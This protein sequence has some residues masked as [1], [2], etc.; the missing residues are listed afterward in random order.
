M[1]SL[2]TVI[3]AVLDDFFLIQKDID[4]VTGLYWNV[5]REAEY[6][7]IKKVIQLT[8]RNKKKA[9][10][11]LG[12]SRNTLDSKLRALKINETDI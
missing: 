3:E 2:L 12:I 7:I 4:D 1:R 5:V 9:S 11:I 6:A 10:R 8:G